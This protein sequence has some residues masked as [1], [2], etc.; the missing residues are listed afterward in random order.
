MRPYEIG[1]PDLDARIRAL[2]A[3]AATK[4]TGNSDLIEEMIITALKLG[5]DDADRGD[6]KIVNTSLKEMRYSYLVFG[7]HRDTKKVTIFGSARTP[8]DDPNY[9]LAA[10]FARVMSDDR[11]WMVITGAGPGIMEAGNLG[12]GRD[13]SFGV[14]IRLP[15]EAEANPHIHE[16]RLIN[17]KYFFT[18]KLMFVKESHAFALFPGGFGTQDETFETLTLIQTG[19]SDIHPIVLLEA[20]GTGYW[21]SW[22]SFVKGT[23]VEQGMIAPDDLELLSQPATILEAADEITA[24]YR[25]YHSQR[26][27]RGRL[28]LRLRHEPTDEVMER[29]NDEYGDLV[30]DGRFERIAATDEEIEDGDVPELPRIRFHFTR[31]NLGRLRALIDTLNETA[32]ATPTA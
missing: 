4:D 26:F 2:V 23:L 27:V 30:A 11:R 13:F 31:R 3:D 9:R 12:A 8:P 14:N 16:S 15:F 25:S 6:L 7:P 32:P 24:F 19:K 1:D 20:P 5:R 17:Y 28:V 22:M 29:I 21:D 18:R 10:D